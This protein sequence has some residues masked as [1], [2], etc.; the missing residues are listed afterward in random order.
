[1]PKGQLSRVLWP[2]N[3]WMLFTFQSA[4]Q[5]L[6]QSNKHSYSLQLATQTELCSTS[7]QSAISV[8]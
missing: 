5:S 1:M 7:L 2:G 6:Q 4:L 3:H 8:F